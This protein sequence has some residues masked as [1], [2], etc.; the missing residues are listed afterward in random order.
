MGKKFVHPKNQKYELRHGTATLRGITNQIHVYAKSWHLRCSRIASYLNTDFTITIFMLVLLPFLSLNQS[1]DQSVE[2]MCAHERAEPT[3]Y[4]A[5]AA[6]VHVQVF[7]VQR[8]KRNKKQ[9]HE[10]ET[11]T[12]TSHT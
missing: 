10:E 12:K 3:S 7:R 8:E 11:T 9:I 1:L 6:A 4:A 2:P 5:A